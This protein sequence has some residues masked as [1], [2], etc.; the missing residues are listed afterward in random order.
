MIEV[1]ELDSTL[2]P[3]QI[4]S[5]QNGEKHVEYLRL[6]PDLKPEEVARMNLPPRPDEVDIDFAPSVPIR[7]ARV[8]SLR[9][10]SRSSPQWSP[11][12]SPQRSPQPS[13]GLDGR[14]SFAYSEP[15]ELVSTMPPLALDPALSRTTSHSTPSLARPDLKQHATAPSASSWNRLSTASAEG[16][17]SPAIDLN[18]ERN[19]WV[20]DDD[21]TFGRDRGSISMTFE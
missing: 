6:P 21:E 2:P 19:A 18:I 13:P 1:R 14:S 9:P 7:P 11:R 12:S 5:V 16:R 10:S 3:M 17:S 8:S 4:T 15:R 20:D